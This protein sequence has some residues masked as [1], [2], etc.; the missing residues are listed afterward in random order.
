MTAATQ[1]TLT[2]GQR[3]AL[4]VLLKNDQAG[5]STITSVGNNPRQGLIDGNIARRLAR[6]GYVGVRG[7][8]HLRSAVLTDAGRERAQALAG[9]EANRG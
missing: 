3:I 9:E 5:K 7:A 2:V 1:P 6:L 4:A 8:E